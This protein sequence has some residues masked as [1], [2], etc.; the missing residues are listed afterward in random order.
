LREGFPHGSGNAHAALAHTLVS[1]PAT[2]SGPSTAGAV[3]SLAAVRLLRLA[4]GYAGIS[5][6]PSPTLCHTAPLLSALA[7]AWRHNTSCL[8]TPPH[9]RSCGSL[10]VHNAA[11]RISRSDTES[12]EREQC[13]LRRE[14]GSPR[15]CR[16]Q[17]GLR[18]FYRCS[19]PLDD[20]GAGVDG[21]PGE[22]GGVEL[23]QV[24]GDVTNSDVGTTHAIRLRDG[25]GGSCAPG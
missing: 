14:E 5:S 23:E 18:P 20:A 11:I 7:S 13:A 8:R 1:T 22:G 4:A 24:V 10:T 9:T 16:R 3:W 25:V 2:L 15:P 19:G 21:A 17:H 12:R 6:L